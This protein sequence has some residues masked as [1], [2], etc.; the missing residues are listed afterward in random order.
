MKNKKTILLLISLIGIMVVFITQIAIAPAPAPAIFFGNLTRDGKPAPIGTMIR[1]FKVGGEEYPVEDNISS[2][3]GEYGIKVYDGDDGDTII[4]KINNF[5][6]NNA[7]FWNFWNYGIQQLDIICTNCNNPPNLVNGTVDKSSGNTSTTFRYTVTYKDADN[8]APIWV[9]LTIDSNVS[10]KMNG[11]YSNAT[12]INELKNSRTYW[13]EITLRQ[14]NHNYTFTS[15]DGFNISE[16]SMQGGPTIV[17]IPPTLSNGKVT[18]TVGNNFDTYNFS[19]IYADYDNDTPVYINVTIIGSSASY[20][21]IATDPGDGD[22]TDGKSYHYTT[23]TLEPGQHSFYFIASDRYNKTETST[24]SGPLVGRLSNRTED[25]TANV[26][27]LVNLTSETNAT[28]EIISSQ[29]IGNA[30]VNITLF[31]TNPT[32]ASFSIPGLGKYM[33]V[34]ISSELNASLTSLMLRVYYTQDEIDAQNLNESSLRFYWYNESSLT[35]VP[36]NE[37][38]DWV[39][40]TGVDTTNVSK[41]SGNVWANVSHVSY[42]TIGGEALA[43]PYTINLQQGW[44]LISIPLNLLEG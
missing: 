43:I 20:T 7:T 9:N 4:F 12:G 14:G 29:D 18:P 17:N 35:W 28:L 37:S 30:S 22:V 42:Y 1:A 39:F 19:V 25:F 34:D 3:I 38:W 21:M 10:Y 15:Y 13:Y 6:A 27:T 40:G 32:N 24:E 36:L 31:T 11:N 33:K 16:T 23:N 41:Y 26:S 8:D 5:T 2:R 44:N